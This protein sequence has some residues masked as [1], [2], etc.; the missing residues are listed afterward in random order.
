MK[1]KAISTLKF[2][3]YKNGMRLPIIILMSM[4]LSL[5]LFLLQSCQLILVVE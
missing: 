3:G 1:R 4:E 2:I 5:L